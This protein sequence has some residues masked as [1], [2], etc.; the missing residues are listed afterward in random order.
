MYCTR[1]WF[2]LKSA[3]NYLYSD[4]HKL[5]LHEERPEAYSE[6]CQIFKME[7]LLR[8]YLHVLFLVLNELI[9][10]LPRTQCS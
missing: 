6:A 1:I 7:L 8:D 4:F 2:A 9:N 3:N 5:N 10:F